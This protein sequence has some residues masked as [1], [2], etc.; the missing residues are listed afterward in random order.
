MA[1]V[2]KHAAPLSSYVPLY[3]GL[4]AY[5]TNSQTIDASKVK[6]EVIEKR[7]KERGVKDLK[8]YN[9]KFHEGLYAIPNFLRTLYYN[10]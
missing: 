5:S 9:G 10:K 1:S 8:L 4:M 6:A 2:F 3:G 7:L